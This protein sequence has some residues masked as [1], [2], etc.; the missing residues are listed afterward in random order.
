[1]QTRQKL[2]VISGVLLSALVLGL[3]ALIRPD[4]GASTKPPGT[5][6]PAPGSDTSMGVM[7]N[8]H[9]S[10]DDDI[11]VAFNSL[12]APGIT[13][14]NIAASTPAQ[15]FRTIKRSKIAINDQTAQIAIND[16]LYPLRAYQ[17][18][19]TPNDPSATQ[20]WTS[21]TSL[22]QAWSVS[23][24]GSN[25]T[26]AIIDTG[27][28]LAH[29]EFAGRW[30]Q[31]SGELGGVSSENP[32][33]LNCT[34]RGLAIQ[35]NCNLVDDDMDGIVDEESGSATVQ[36]P[37][38]LN[39]TALS[40]PLAKDCNNIDD[41]ANG[42]VD[43]VTGWDFMN[44]DAS[45]QA[46]QLSPGG[47]GTTHGTMVAGVAA[48]TGNNG[49]GIAGVNWQAKILPIQA[50]DDD[51]YGDTVSVGMSIYYAVDQDV[52]VISISLG[53]A[54][55]DPFVKEAIE[56]ATKSGIVVVA[57]SGNDGCDCISYPARY[58]EV[59]AVGAI[60]S[61]NAPASFSSWGSELDVLAPG[62]DIRTTTWSAANSTSNYISGVAGTSFATPYV[63]GLIA[64]MKSLQPGSNPLQL[65][66]GLGES[67]TKPSAMAGQ[68][69]STKYGF[70]TTNANSTLTRMSTPKTGLQVYQFTPI[71]SG[72]YLLNNNSYEIAGNY[73][74]HSCDNLFGTTPVYEL[75]KANSVF[76][77]ISK[78]EVQRAL[79][80]GYTVRQF[81]Y[82]CIQQNHDSYTLFRLIDIFKEFRNDYSIR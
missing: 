58:S 41:D 50:L 31:N 29:E 34:D 28:A 70:G 24:G 35:A 33:R 13:T 23:T 37:S 43:D 20:W 18:L 22:P 76:Y 2:G 72:A 62:T 80:Q 49:K 1:M 39:C 71:Q 64:S 7:D 38:K 78:I 75:T 16:K 42:Y 51:G 47:S 67:A 66:G 3:F 12:T 74:V 81:T 9:V 77:S 65:I 54:F 63:A 5:P 10:A 57:A 32:S 19:L 8:G 48:A 40:R 21:D 27:F 25:T 17:Q 4:P 59:V 53:T 11:V 30:Y 45:V 69:Y 73:R 6:T 60:N 61:S 82:A 79:A 36:N 56:Y 46:G 44:Q 26:I 15:Q 52:D 14:L 55:N 68:P